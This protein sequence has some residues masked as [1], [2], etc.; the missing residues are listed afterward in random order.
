MARRSAVTSPTT[1][2]AVR[3]LARLGVTGWVLI[4]VLIGGVLFYEHFAGASED[5]GAAPPADAT[6]VADRADEWSPDDDPGPPPRSS[7]PVDP[8]PVVADAPPARTA[9]EPPAETEPE[10]PAQPRATYAVVTVTLKTR[11]GEKV[12]DLDPDAVLARSDGGGLAL[13][14]ALRGGERL[15]TDCA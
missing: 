12:V 10:P 8:P 14:A 7:R 5:G 15:K 2:A 1:L 13:A 3:H 4:A 6:V 9:P 11:A